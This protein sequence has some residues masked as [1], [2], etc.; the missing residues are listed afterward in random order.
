MFFGEDRI[1]VVQQMILAE[2]VEERRA[3]LDKLLPFQKEDFK[4]I[5][6]AMEG[7]PVIIRLLDPP[8]HEFL[9]SYEELLVEV[10]TM[11]VKGVSD[12]SSRRNRRSLPELTGCESSILCWGIEDAA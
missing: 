2:T 11:K 8:L 10:A 3:A 4:G 5:L 1:R 9:P 12:K 6:K 7:H